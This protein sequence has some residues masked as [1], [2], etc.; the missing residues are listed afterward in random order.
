MIAKDSH[1]KNLPWAP[2]VR[3]LAASSALIYALV[4]FFPSATASAST[5]DDSWLQTL[6]VAFEQRWQFGRDI[7][8][9]F[10]PFGFLCGGYYPPTFLI[11]AAVWTMLALVFW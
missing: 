1:Q 4:Q 9:T 7:V 10:G 8:F 11:S 5:I 6:H 3:W 2:A